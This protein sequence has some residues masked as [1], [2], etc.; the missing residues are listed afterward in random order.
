M[1]FAFVMDCRRMHYQQKCFAAI[2]YMMIRRGKQPQKEKKQQ[3]NIKHGTRQQCLVPFFYEKN[4][5]MYQ[6]C[7]LFLVE[8]YRE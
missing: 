1:N 2:L 4:R 3:E 6:K 7:N 5:D 8:Y